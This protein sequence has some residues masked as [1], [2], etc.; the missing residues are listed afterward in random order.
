MAGI[1]PDEIRPTP[2]IAGIEPVVLDSTGL[3]ITG[4]VPV[5]EAGIIGKEPVIGRWIDG[6]G[7]KSGTVGGTCIGA[8]C[9][10]A[11]CIGIGAEGAG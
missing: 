11:G 10:G 5:F 6:C 8:G 1:E 2:D 9:I 7:A 4:R 3:G